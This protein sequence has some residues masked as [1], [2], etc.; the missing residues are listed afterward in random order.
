MH[1]GKCLLECTR[2]WN[3]RSQKVQSR[4]MNS[5]QPFL[6][7]S[8]SSHTSKIVKKTGK[9]NGWDVQDTTLTNGRGLVT[10]LRGKDFLVSNDAAWIREPLKETSP[11]LRKLPSQGTSILAGGQADTTTLRNHFQDSPL[12]SAILPS[13]GSFSWSLEQRGNLMMLRW[14]NR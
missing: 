3:K 7:T 9:V 14:A 12:L 11:T 2:A 10:A 1:R 5:M 6:L 4:A 13:D 8:F